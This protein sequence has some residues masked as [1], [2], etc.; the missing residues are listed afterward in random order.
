M[1]LVNHDVA[2]VLSLFHTSALLTIISIT[3]NGIFLGG[4]WSR[5]SGNTAVSIENIVLM[6][7]CLNEKW[8]LLILRQRSEDSVYSENLSAH[9]L[10]LFTITSCFIRY[11]HELTR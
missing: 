4:I 3:V 11:L 9:Y 2:K 10:E 7:K 8:Y 5:P 1:K 6:R